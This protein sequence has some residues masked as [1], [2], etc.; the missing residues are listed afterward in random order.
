LAESS[1]VVLGLECRGGMVDD[2]LWHDLFC[3]MA[4]LSVLSLLRVVRLKSIRTTC[5]ELH[6][7]TRLITT[8]DI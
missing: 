5:E 7:Y 6:L 4:A 1:F 8:G 3:S 2:P